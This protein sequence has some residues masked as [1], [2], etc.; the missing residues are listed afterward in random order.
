VEIVPSETAKKAQAELDAINQ[1]YSVAEVSLHRNK[2]KSVATMQDGTKQELHPMA[3]RR[4]I[5]LRGWL[6]EWGRKLKAD[7][8]CVVILMK[9]DA[10]RSGRETSSEQSSEASLAPI[11]SKPSTYRYRE[12]IDSDP[13]EPSEED[14]FRQLVIDRLPEWP[15]YF[16]RESDDDGPEKYD[17]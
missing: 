2:R 6:R 11:S 16:I 13:E 1:R 9:S 8:L 10:L 5:E 15:E 17:E 14:E 4:R 12:D 3:S 7:G